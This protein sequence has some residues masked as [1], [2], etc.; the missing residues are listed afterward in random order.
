MSARRRGA[1]ATAGRGGA[2]PA[3]RARLCV[4]AALL[5]VSPT[6]AFDLGGLAQGLLQNTDGIAALLGGIGEDQEHRLGQGASA[7]L[8]GAAPL[9]DDDNAQRYLNRVGAWLARHTER[10]ELAWRFGVLDTASVN[11]FA[12]PGGYVFVSRG[13]LLLARDEAELAGVLA[14]EMSHVLARHHLEAMADRE[15]FRLVADVAL[16]ATD[17]RGVLTDALVGIAREMYAKGLEQSDEFEADGMGVVIAARAGY[18]PRGL[19][20]VL[21]AIDARAGD[22]ESTGFFLATHPPTA[23]R[24]DRLAATFE[25]SPG[26]PAPPRGGA[27]DAI[28]ARIAAW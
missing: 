25:P 24:L 16:E 11:A 1:R 27:F 13:L 5:L 26:A 20:R 23:E 22:A 6:R 18:D 7:V 10:P 15:R 9:L 4:L 17:A 2:R 14:H 8:L 12:A 3:A 28:K 21:R 19:Q